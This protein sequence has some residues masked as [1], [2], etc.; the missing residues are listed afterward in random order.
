MQVRVSIEANGKVSSVT[1]L[2]GSGHQAFDEAAERAAMAETF[3]P[4]T[5]DGKPVAYT[6]SYSYRFRIEEN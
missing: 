1:V 2:K 3:T 4:A 6:L 5:R